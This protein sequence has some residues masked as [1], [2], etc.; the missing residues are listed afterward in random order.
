MRASSGGPPS[1]K[2]SVKGIIDIHSKKDLANETAVLSPATGVTMAGLP[3]T[4]VPPCV[5]RPARSATSSTRWNISRSGLR[6]GSIWRMV[7]GARASHSRGGG[8]HRV[9]RGAG[10][11]EH[12]Q[13]D[14]RDR[15]AAGH[16]PAL[17]PIYR[18]RE[19]Q[20]EKQRHGHR[21]EYVLGEVEQRSHRQHGEQDDRF[22]K[23]GIGEG[24]GCAHRANVRHLL[25][26][27]QAR[28]PHA[29]TE[30]A[31]ADVGRVPHGPAPYD[32]HI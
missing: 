20:R 15:E 13:E 28:M 23:R 17:Q 29:G 19:Q 31:R 1:M 4:A 32:R 25:T 27:R 21:N 26:R 3:P 12:H 10:G 22:A 5:S 14:N 2:N 30:F 7:C 6:R 11:C 16:A 24:G 9:D 18:G 8:P